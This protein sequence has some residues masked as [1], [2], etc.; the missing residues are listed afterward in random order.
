MVQGEMST[1]GGQYHDGRGPGYS[2]G[3]GGGA[4][5]DTCKLE[6]DNGS[7]R[8]I[9]KFLLQEREDLIRKVDSSEPILNPRLT[10]PEP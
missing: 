4:A 5:N 1:A 3:Y 6:E 2:S 9:S 8:A 7:L 10:G